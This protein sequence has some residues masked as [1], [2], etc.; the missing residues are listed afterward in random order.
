[1][2]A[3]DRYA[4]VLRKGFDEYRS[5]VNPLVAQRASLTGEPMRLVQACEGHLLDPQG[6]PLEDFHGTQAFGHRHPAIAQA[7]RDYLDS[8]AP[9]WFPSRVNPFAGR[10]ARMLSERTGYDNAYFGCTGSDAVEAALKLARALTRRPKILGLTGG[11]HGCTF[12]SL[13]IMGEGYLRDPFGP[14]LP[15]AESVPFGDVDALSSAMAG[16]DVAA[17]VV[18]PI[19]GEGGVRELPGPFVEAL[20]ELTARHRTL[21]VADEV[22]T[23]LG[24][25]GLGFL[26]S[27]RWP[28]RPDVV[29][30][31]KHLGGG[32][33][34][35][36]AMLTRRELF[37]QAY[38]DHFASGES[39]NSTLS[40]TALSCVAAMAALE[41]LDEATITRVSTL[42]D[43]LKQR[44]ADA[45]GASPLFR[46]ARGRGFMLGVAL[47]QPDHPWLSFEHFG[48]PP[49][50]G[51][52]AVIAPL[53]CHR[54]YQRGF[55][56]FSC[57]H[58]WSILRLQPRFD[59]P[60]ARLD[61]F[62]T[63]LGEEIAYLEEL[64]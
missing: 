45:L 41:L 47:H 29:L 28:R 8:D 12:G 56:C 6:R 19:Q 5:F 38:G 26:A 18:E 43:R 40:A 22:Q 4:D 51:R 64:C 1:M 7:I 17:I 21:L 58:D 44:M 37:L 63:A 60:E 10:L 11:Y 62:V 46:E 23:A 2:S 49:D 25:T 14:H 35:I 39:H 52:K 3:P 34:P 50:L 61:E 32:L 31:A 16:G 36:S 53:L 33:A 9:S 13:A 15:V 20:C 27:A 54:L 48:F 55:F 30:L 42:G 59:L 57:G 24:R